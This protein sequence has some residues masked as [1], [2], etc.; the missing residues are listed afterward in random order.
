VSVPAPRIRV[1]PRGLSRIDAAAYV[2]ISPSKFDQLIQ[3]GVMP[4]PRR[5]D[6]R[7]LWDRYA[8]DDAFENLPSDEAP[9][10]LDNFLKP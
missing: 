3:N 8:L 10:P 5:I 2:G 4:R 9:N 1:E 7:V 6:G